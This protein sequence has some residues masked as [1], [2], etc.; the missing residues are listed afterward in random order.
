MINM[1]MIN[2]SPIDSE[3][4]A[5]NYCI[6]PM[7]H[8]RMASLLPLVYIFVRRTLSNRASGQIQNCHGRSNPGPMNS[9]PHRPL[10]GKS[11]TPHRRRGLMRVPSS[12]ISSDSASKVGGQTVGGTTIICLRH[13]SRHCRDLHTNIDRSGKSSSGA[14]SQHK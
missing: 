11:S 6:H 12:K 3:R 1:Q 4:A 2:L 5:Y 9:P 14:L 8:K 7:A 13:F 10:P